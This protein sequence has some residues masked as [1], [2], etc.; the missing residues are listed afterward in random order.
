[1]KVLVV[2]SPVAE[3]LGHPH[4]AFEVEASLLSDPAFGP[5]MP[6]R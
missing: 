5:R 1:M 6:R 3:P 4:G 2:E